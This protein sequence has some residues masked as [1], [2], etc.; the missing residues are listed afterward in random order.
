MRY[1]LARGAAI[2]FGL[3]TTSC[4]TPNTPA[5]TEAAASGTGAVQI[6]GVTPG[7][8]SQAAAEIFQKHGYTPGGKRTGPLVFEK[9][10]SKWS[11][12]AYGNWTGGIPIWIR[13][14]LAILPAGEAE[15]TLQ[16]RAFRVR[17]KGGATEEELKIS[18]LD[19]GPYRKLLEEIAS[20][21]QP[22][23]GGPSATP[24]QAGQSP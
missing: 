23:S 4:H 18:K 2:W 16:C 17:D 1:L 19:S 6:R 20:R 22:P 21:F 14:R 15:H 7:Q 24:P 3:V 5:R 13:V 8:I 10:A 9:E 12:L 11:N